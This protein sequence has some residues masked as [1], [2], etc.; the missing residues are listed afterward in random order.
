MTDVVP[1]RHDRWYDFS[2][3]GEAGA[4]VGDWLRAGTTHGLDRLAGADTVII[5]PPPD[6]DASRP[7]LIDA[8]RVAH[9]AGARMVA[10]CTGAFVL[11]EAGLLDGRRATPTGCTRTC[12]SAGTRP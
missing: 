12:C 7:A 4:R 10:L 8:V 5:P 1:V 3:C 6:L 11:A 2:V 9:R